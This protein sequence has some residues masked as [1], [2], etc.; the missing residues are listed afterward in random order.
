MHK[1]TSLKYIFLLI[2]LLTSC[3]HKKDTH[4][5]KETT[6]TSG[7]NTGNS[8]TNDSENSKKMLY[9]II[10]AKQ[11][12]IIAKKDLLF[13]GKMFKEK[14]GSTLADR[15]S[16]VKKINDELNS[17][18]AT[19]CSSISGNKKCS[20]NK[21]TE[22]DFDGGRIEIFNCPECIGSNGPDDSVDGIYHI[23][24][25]DDAVDVGTEPGAQYTQH[26]A[27]GTSTT[28]YKP[29]DA[30]THQIFKQVQNS[31]KTIDYLRKN[32]FTWGT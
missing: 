14:L 4:N 30:E 15:E 17:F 10:Y 16:A 18:Y 13:P 25:W 23:A 29:F 5:T 8:P 6:N 20:L 3:V 12:R 19:K 1:N 28:H 9:A 24:S 31:Q 2:I 7:K 21:V 27:D 22:L 32:G 11:G 26:N